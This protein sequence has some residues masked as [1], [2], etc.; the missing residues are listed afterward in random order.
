MPK[1]R[2][3]PQLD[4]VRDAVE[5]TIQA[6]LGGALETRGRAQDLVRGAEASAEAVRDRVKGAIE[7]GRPATYDDIREL[8]VELREI[9]GRLDAIERELSRARPSRAG[10]KKG[11]GAS[12]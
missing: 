2:T 3:T 11:R 7:V 10:A 4:A 8:R 9:A 6:T 5:R 12:K 1:R